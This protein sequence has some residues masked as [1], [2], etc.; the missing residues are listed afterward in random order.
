MV[1][2]RSKEMVKITSIEYR[3]P[4]IIS[5]AEKERKLLW[6]S[7]K[8]VWLFMQMKLKEYRDEYNWLIRFYLCA[9]SGCPEEYCP[10]CPL[11]IPPDNIKDLCKKTKITKKGILPPTLKMI[12]KTRYPLL[13]QQQL[14]PVSPPS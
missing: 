1:R 3:V 8:R 13:I 5:F 2:E 7:Q 9:V 10:P 14:P 12:L 4:E 11:P 6:T